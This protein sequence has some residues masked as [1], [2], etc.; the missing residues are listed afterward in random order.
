MSK[1]SY[2]SLWQQ[3]DSSISDHED[4]STVC[5]Q[6]SKL[7]QLIGLIYISILHSASLRAKSFGPSV[8]MSLK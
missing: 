5:Q 6:N 3:D 7:E 1:H 4:R 8:S 2:N